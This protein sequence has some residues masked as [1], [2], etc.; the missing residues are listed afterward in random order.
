MYARC[1]T[2]V[3]LLL[4][5]F[6]ICMWVPLLRD[7]SAEWHASPSRLSPTDV[8]GPHTNGGSSSADGPH[9]P[10]VGSSSLPSPPPP[11]QS[12]TVSDEDTD[13]RRSRKKKRKA[14]RSDCNVKCER[15]KVRKNLEISDAAKK[16]NKLLG[17]RQHEQQKA[18]ELWLCQT[19]GG[20]GPTVPTRAVE[21]AWARM[22]RS[23]SPRCTPSDDRIGQLVGLI[24][25]AQI[26]ASVT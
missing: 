13:M 18:A 25:T 23:K 6:S 24:Q 3:A 14:A 22:K 19:A 2:A 17:A 5:M 15:A 11:P 12:P 21:L 7:A 10:D 26:R 4:L 1:E 20:D 9:S 16:R 8:D